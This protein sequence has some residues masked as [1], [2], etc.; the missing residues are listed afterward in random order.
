VELAPRS[1]IVQAPSED[2]SRKDEPVLAAE[3]KPE[4]K[5]PLPTVK[6]PDAL[7]L[8]R[9]AVTTGKDVSISGIVTDEAGGVLPGTDITLTNIVN[10][11]AEAAV[12][13][14][15]GA[16]SF[17]GLP[18]G[19]YAVTA[20]MFGFQKKTYTN[21][22]LAEAMN[23]RLDFKLPIAGLKEEV[24]VSIDAASVL[25]EPNP[26]VGM[27]MPEKQAEFQRDG[28]T[29]SDVRFAPGVLSLAPASPSQ[30]AKTQ[31]VLDPVDAELAGTSV[32]YIGSGEVLVGDEKSLPADRHVQ[33]GVGKLEIALVE[34]L[35]DA[36]YLHAA[37]HRRG[38][39]AE[40]RYLEQVAEL[41]ARVLESR[42]GYIGDI[43][44]GDAEVDRRGL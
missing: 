33:A 23:R 9:S 24:E 30:V 17:S 40:G 11:V 37:A 8:A 36:G 27:V 35:A 28:V 2:T 38:G 6:I 41:G 19:I 13:N 20:E 7:A 18:T 32:G 15:S 31:T 5:L 25:L 12:A 21:I 1:V 16:Y 39:I 43:I 22:Q 10:G 42:R 29:I 44:A 34:L 14:D 26:S 3:K 4:S